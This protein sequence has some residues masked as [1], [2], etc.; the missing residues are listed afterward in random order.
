MKKREIGS[1]DDNLVF[2]KYGLENKL[3]F[4]ADV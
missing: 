4:M 3:N 2:M 1:F